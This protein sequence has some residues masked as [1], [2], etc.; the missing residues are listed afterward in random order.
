MIYVYFC[1]ST[2][3]ISANH[4]GIFDLMGGLCKIKKS[5]IKF[6]SKIPRVFFFTF[7]SR[8]STFDIYLLF[9]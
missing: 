6:L 5:K 4:A 8:I 9:I 1:N 7:L 2:Q 3:N